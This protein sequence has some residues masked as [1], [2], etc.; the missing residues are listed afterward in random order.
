MAFLWNLGHWE[1]LSFLHG[2]FDGKCAHGVRMHAW[3][4]LYGNYV[5]ARR[6]I[7]QAFWFC[8]YETSRSGNFERI[9]H[10]C[11][12]LIDGSMIED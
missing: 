2:M 1:I 9:E 8:R 6:C 7:A 3:E 12:A 5:Y 10:L 4:T 11:R